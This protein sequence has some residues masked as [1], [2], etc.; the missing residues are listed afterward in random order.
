VSRDIVYLARSKS[1]QTHN[2]LLQGFSATLLQV[3]SDTDHFLLEVTHS[4]KSL[5]GCPCESDWIWGGHFLS[6]ALL[7]R[8]HLTTRICGWTRRLSIP[9]I[10]CFLLA[11]LVTR[12]ST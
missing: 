2:P 7:Q 6:A 3:E 5:S 11:I 4:Y 9:T 12:P 8:V 10:L 1:H